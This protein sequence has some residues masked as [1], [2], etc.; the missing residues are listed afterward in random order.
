MT[1]FTTTEILVVSLQQ[2]QDDNEPT[3]VSC[4]H[5]P[6]LAICGADL[7]DST[8]VDE[9]DNECLVCLDLEAAEDAMPDWADCICPCC[10]EIPE[11]VAS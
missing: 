3:H 10:V 7:T 1:T 2:T 11:D 8:V 9:A 6:D 5:N 4:C